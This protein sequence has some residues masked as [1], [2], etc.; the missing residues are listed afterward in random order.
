MVRSG[1]VTILA[2]IVFAAAAL[3]GPVAAG[4]A[5]KQ[6]RA[7]A[8]E[9][10]LKLRDRVR[11]AQKDRAAAKQ[12]TLDKAGKAPAR[13]KSEATTAARDR[14]RQFEGRAKAEELAAKQPAASKGAP[15]LDLSTRE[16]KLTVAPGKKK[17][18][19]RGVPFEGRHGTGLG[20]IF[21]EEP[22]DFEAE[23]IDDLPVNIVGEIGVD[24]DTDF[25]AIT[26][27]QGES[28]RI[29]VIADRI[30]GTFLDSYVVVLAEDGETLLAENDDFFQGSTDSFIRFVAPN[31]G[32]QLYFIGVT[33]FGGFGGSGYEYVLSIAPAVAPDDGEEEFNDTT[34]TA[35]VLRVPSMMFGFSDTDDDID[36]YTFQGSGSRTLVVDVDA[37]LFLSEM[38]AVVELYDDRGGYLFGVD[39]ADG[40]DPRFNILLPYT[41]QYYLVVYNRDA[42]GGDD[43]YYS[44]NI[45]TQDGSDS[46]R[47]NAF[48][49][50][51]GRFLKR[52][53]GSGFT[54][55]NGGTDA[56]I[57]SGL[58]PSRPGPKKPTTVVK[59]TP[60]VEV[61]D[62]D[63]VT[64]VNPDGR[65]SNPGLVQ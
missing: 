39:D 16:K 41:G 45:S 55:N 47:I 19:K 56:E 53:L 58:V 65:R 28:I 17:A 50:V 18:A 13:V 33:D 4:A 62:N 64:V 34:G 63:V 1:A 3:P 9:L 37:E 15:R 12:S 40:L 21:E 11:Q 31:A 26:A 30:F 46:P 8:P 29:E 24:E 14:A 5:E 27:Q 35:D 42:I 48:K 57:N 2:A 52:V 32:E 59:L 61:F 43:Y 7:D 44:V 60:A 22:N 54:P 36:V 20:D 49:I 51:N 23:I 25:F 10:T 38:D 6:Q